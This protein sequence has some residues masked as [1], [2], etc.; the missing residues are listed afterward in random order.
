MNT[1]ANDVRV[2][3]RIDKNLKISAEYLFER[4]GLNMTT[5]FNVFLRKAVEE[6][7]IPFSVSTKSIGIGGDLSANDVTNAFVN[8]VSSEISNAKKHNFPIAGYDIKTQRA[9]LENVDGTREYIDE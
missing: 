2:T 8:T 1:G 6:N 3:V 9:Y 5:A 7:A 4:L